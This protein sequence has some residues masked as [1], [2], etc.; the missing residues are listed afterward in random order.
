MALRPV[1][2]ASECPNLKG[3]ACLGAG[4]LCMEQKAN[5]IGEFQIQGNTT[6]ED[7][8]EGETN[9]LVLIKQSSRCCLRGLR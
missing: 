1:A 4:D 9:V 5:A 2:E 7:N 6:R 3:G 8:N